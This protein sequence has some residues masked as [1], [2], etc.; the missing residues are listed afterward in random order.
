MLLRGVSLT[1]KLMSSGQVYHSW[2]MKAAVEDCEHTHHKFLLPDDPAPQDMVSSVT[3]TK[4][5][6]RSLLTL[7]PGRPGFP[8]G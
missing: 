7:E 1:G 2:V 8:Q 6:T 3:G 4:A 5:M